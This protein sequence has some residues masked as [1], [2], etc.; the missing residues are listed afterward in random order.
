MPD[1]ELNGRHQFAV[2]WRKTGT[3][4]YGKPVL[5]DAEE[6]VVRWENVQKEVQGPQ[7]EPL[8]VLAEVTVDNEIPLG[9]VMWEGTL[10]DWLGT[11]SAGSDVDLREVL[12]KETVPDIHG[13]VSWRIVNLGYYRGNK[14]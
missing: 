14:P 4:R 8:T 6:Q 13:R 11:G 9:S 5:D 7:G 10:D 2:L 12:G 1:P 3:D